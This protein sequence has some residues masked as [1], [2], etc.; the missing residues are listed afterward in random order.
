MPDGFTSPSGRPK[1]NIEGNISRALELKPDLVII[2][3]PTNDVANNY[4]EQEIIANFESVT[5]NLRAENIPFIITGTQPRSLSVEK[6]QRLKNLNTKLR[7]VY[8][9]KMFDYYNLLSTADDL[10]Q[11]EYSAGDGVHM[12]NAGHR[13]IYENLFQLDVFKKYLNEH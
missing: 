2:N 1:P 7:L 11:K 9:S 13:I 12:N 6:R 3:L 5:E 8:E 10:I 4:N